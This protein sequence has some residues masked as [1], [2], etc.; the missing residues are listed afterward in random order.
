MKISAWFDNLTPI[1]QDLV[2]GGFTWV[3]TAVG[4]AIVIHVS[5]LLPFALSFAAGAM[6]N[7]VGD[8]LVPETQQEGN[9]DLATLCL[10]LGFVVMM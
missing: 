9:E 7:V 1:L 2:A 10:M 4:A 3:L 5:P 6:V 8:E